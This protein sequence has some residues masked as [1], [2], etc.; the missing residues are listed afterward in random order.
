M[1]RLF[2]LI[3]LVPVLALLAA[4]GATPAA[5]APTAVPAMPTVAP[6]PTTAPTVAPEP[7]ALPAA[8]ESTAVPAA[9]AERTVSDTLGREVTL[10]GVPTRIVSLAP[11]VTEILFAIGAGPQVVGVTTFCNF[12]PEADALPEVGGFSVSTISIESIV[13]L[14]PELVIAGAASQLAVA[15]ALEPLGIPTMIMT[16]DDLEGVFANIEQLGTITGNEDQAAATLAEMRARIDAVAATV[17]DIPAEERP[18]VFWEV[19]DEPLMTAGPNTFIGQLLDIAGTENIF[20]DASEDYPQISAEAIVE[21]NPAVIMGS[22]THAEKLTPELVAARPGWIE[23]AAVRDGRIYLINGDISS[24]PGPRLADA[25][26]AIVRA[27][28]PEYFN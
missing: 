28:Y 17:A 22:D 9:S 18:S 7:T 21:R 3:L 23:I 1:P 10:N 11:S 13:D 24:R 12:P 27:L 2:K 6:E 20:A 14:Q 19:F 16:P 5:P 26:E 15:E 8:T 25:L 4:C